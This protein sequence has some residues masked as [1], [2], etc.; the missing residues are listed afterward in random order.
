MLRTPIP[1]GFAAGLCT[2]A[3]AAA[4]CGGSKS[5]AEGTVTC[6]AGTVDTGS[7]TFVPTSGGDQAVKVS[8]RVFDGKYTIDESQGLAPGK[9]KVEIN[10]NKK[11][12]RR[13][14]TGDGASWDETKEGLPAKYNTQSD[15]TADVKPGP[16]TLN[17]DLKTK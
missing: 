3:F 15:L 17:F 11:T 14:S 16:N 10:W 9:Y 1:R 2:L 5:S 6:D 8:G 7:V 13:V 12:G 4:G